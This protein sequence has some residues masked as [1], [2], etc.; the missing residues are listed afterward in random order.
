MN[1]SKGVNKA[2]NYADYFKGVSMEFLTEEDE[3]NRL[4]LRLY[5]LQQYLAKEPGKPVVNI[6]E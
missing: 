6:G 5:R 2:S 4:L 3:L 1:D